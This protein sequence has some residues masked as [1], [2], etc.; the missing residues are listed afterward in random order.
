MTFKSG[1]TSFTLALTLTGLIGTAWLFNQVLPPEQL[2]ELVESAG[3]W[4]YGLFVF[5]YVVATLLILPSTAFN[6]AGGVLFGGFWGLVITTIA[7]AIAAT[8]AFAL[9]RLLDR[10]TLFG[11]MPRAFQSHKSGELL[12]TQLRSNGIAYIAALRILPLIPYG[13]VSFTAGLSPIRFRDYLLGTLI[14][15]PL[16]FAPFIWLGNAGVQFNS[17]S[18]IVSL[19]GI[20]A[21]VIVS[22]YLWKQQPKLNAKLD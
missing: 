5:A 3:F 17:S 20:L 9:A 2:R 12:E 15:T 1:T 16:G 8:I 21:L 7:A 22:V 19:L 14:G 13:I 18:I 4:G 6:L 10:D 11:I